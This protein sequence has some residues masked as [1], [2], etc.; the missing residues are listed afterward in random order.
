MNV[1]EERWYVGESRFTEHPVI[2][3]AR[4]G[5]G[6][7]MPPL[8]ELSFAT[9]NPIVASRARL[10]AAA[11]DLYAALELVLEE[12]EDEHPVSCDVRPCWVEIAD[13]ALAKARGE[14]P[15]ARE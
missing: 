4:E 3:I 14:T 6:E 12:L 1:R 13:A 15:D 9:D 10:M 8:A 11:P 2:V 5:D 7:D